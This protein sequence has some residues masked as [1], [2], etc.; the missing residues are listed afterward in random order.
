[1]VIEHVECDSRLVSE[2]TLFVAIAGY[3]NDG[4]DFVKDARERGA[5]AVLG[6]RDHCDDIDVHVQVPDARKALSD[7]AAAFY[8]GPGRRL[9]FCGVTGTN[10]KSTTCHLLKG[11]LE[12]RGKVV[13]LISSNVYDTGKETFPAERTTPESLDMQRLLFLMRKNFCVN[14][15]VEV[16]S[17]ALALKRVE[18]ISFRVAV[19]TN[20]TRDH[21]DFH[22][23]MENYLKAKKELL[24][25][26]DGPLSYAVINLDVPEF[27]DLFGE[28]RGSYI[29]YSLS[30]AT[31]DVYCSS[32]SIEK[33]RTVFSLVTPM[34][35]ETV[36][37]SLPGRFNLINAIAAASAGLASGVDLDNVIRGLEKARPVPGRFNFIDAGQ[38]FGVYTDYAHTPDA[39]ERLC[40]TAREL[41]E[42]RLF[43]LFGCGGDR[44]RGKRPMMGKA[45]TNGADFAV[46]T[47]D[48]PRPGRCDITSQKRQL[49]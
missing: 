29:G 24:H 17:H 32:Y 38:P 14:A 33:S 21:L 44:D 12:E 46:V 36:T 48:N 27:R 41:C 1:M 6:E 42:G 26:L 13:G 30:D 47:S 10:G 37:L 49:T 31:A 3:E 40:E 34:G 28:V 8:G 18:N 11:I 45:A 5:V 35:T 43:I 4:Y 20:L 23:T 25:K 19:F 15:V 2:G 9:K 22:E 39:I 7:V 16:S